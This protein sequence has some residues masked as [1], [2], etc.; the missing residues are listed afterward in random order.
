MKEEFETAK[1]AM[2]NSILLNSFD[3]NK[4]MLVLTDASGDGFGYILLQRMENNVWEARAQATR[5][6]TG[7]VTM[8]TCWVVIQV[9]SAALKPAWRIT[10][11]WNWKQPALYGRSRPCLTT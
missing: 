6:R 1:E 2:G 4:R 7:E 10:A 8:D 5:G 11:P 9:G 3:V